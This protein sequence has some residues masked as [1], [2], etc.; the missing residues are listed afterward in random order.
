MTVRPRTCTGRQQILLDYADHT[1][2][3]EGDR[4]AGEAERRQR[5]RS[6]GRCRHYAP[7][8][9]ITYGESV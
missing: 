9:T 7:I 5:L 4:P 1:G 2:V 8:S 6:R 3:A